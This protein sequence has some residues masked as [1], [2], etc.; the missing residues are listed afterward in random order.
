MLR[1]SKIIKSQQGTI[2]QHVLNQVDTI[3]ATLQQ[4][5]VTDKVNRHTLVGQAWVQKHR[6]EGE[7]ARLDLL[8]HS[9]LRPIKKIRCK[10]DRTIDDAIDYLPPQIA[11]HAHKTHNQIKRISGG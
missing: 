4:L 1:I 8:V 7:M 6:L 9:S 2:T 3:G 10:V 11:K 5:G